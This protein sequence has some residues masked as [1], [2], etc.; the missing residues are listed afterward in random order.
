MEGKFS[1]LVLYSYSSYE[2]WAGDDKY[3]IFE[4][5]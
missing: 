1:D 2:P 4:L 5:T 3:K